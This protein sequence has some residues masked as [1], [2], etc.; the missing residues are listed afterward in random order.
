[1]RPSKSRP[2]RTP[3]SPEPPPRPTPAGPSTKPADAQRSGASAGYLPGPA[4]VS[5]GF[6]QS[7]AVGRNQLMGRDGGTGVSPVAGCRDGGTGVPPVAGCRD[8]G[9]GVPPVA[10]CRSL[11][12]TIDFTEARPQGRGTHTVF[13]VPRA[14]RPPVLDRDDAHWR[15]PRAAARPCLTRTT[16]TGGC[17]GRLARPCL[18]GTTHTGGCHGRLARPCLTGTTHTGGCHGRLAR[19]CLTGTTHTGGQA[20]SGTH[21]V[22]VAHTPCQRHTRRTSAALAS[23]APSPAAGATVFRP[24]H[25]FRRSP[26]SRPWHPA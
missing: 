21:T 24:C 5:T 16:H 19:P 26:A 6:H 25:R 14:A 8:G 18:T 9:T 1:M 3:T 11:D 13:R 20:A 23:P 7:A 10:G 22:P 17:H 15:V 2:R 12:R 4:E